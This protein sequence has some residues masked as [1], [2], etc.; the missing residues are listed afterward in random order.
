MNWR[1]EIAMFGGATPQRCH[2]CGTTH[3]STFP[4]PSPKTPWVEEEATGGQV[5]EDASIRRWEALEALAAT[6][7]EAAARADAMARLE[8]ALQGL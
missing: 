8:R 2:K 4:C 6:S 5:E 7:K 1:V 3:W